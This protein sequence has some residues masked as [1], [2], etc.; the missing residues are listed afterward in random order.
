MRALFLTVTSICLLAL[1]ACSNDTGSSGVTSDS[2]PGDDNQ[3]SGTDAVSGTDAIAGDVTKSCAVG[4]DTCGAGSYCSAPVGQCSGQGTCA[5]KPQT[6]TLEYGPICGCD[7]KDYGNG[8]EANAAGVV[9][10][11]GGSCNA[12]PTKWYQTC[13]APVCSGVKVDPNTPACTTQK[14]GDA[15]SAGAPE[16]D[17]Q[18]TCQ[19][20]LV[21]ADKDPKTNPGS[22]PISRRER[23]TDIHYLNTT[24]VAKLQG[25]LLATKLATYKYR[26]AG[27]QAP[28]QLGFIIDDQPDSPAVDARRDMVDLYGYL[29]MSVAALQV[30]QRQLAEQ[31]RRIE[32]LEQALR[33]APVCQ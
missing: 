5:V 4:S 16:C 12:A 19:Q 20:H 18:N 31:A 21:C 9:M 32:Q 6:C 30:Q 28:Q 24:D 27:P 13:G 1:S 33:A 29:S 7:G 26:D 2:G 17:L 22:C 25:E 8:C 23:K 14:A 11:K 10:S 15:C 3:I